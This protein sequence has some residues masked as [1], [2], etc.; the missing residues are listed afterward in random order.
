MAH[1]S[2]A[3]SSLS[4]GRSAQ[5][6]NYTMT[7]AWQAVFSDSSSMPWIF[8]GGVIDLTNMADGDVIAVRVRK[9][10]ALGG[11]WILVS[12]LKYANLQPVGKKLVNVSA[13]TDVYGLEISMWQPLVAANYLVIATE[14]FPAKRPGA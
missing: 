10:I 12:Q 5:S 11:A 3:S 14:W 6:G 13:I 8:Y 1:G 9:T 7:A 2:G 4:L